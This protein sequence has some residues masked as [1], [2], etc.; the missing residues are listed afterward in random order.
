MSTNEP[1]VELVN[2]EIP[3]YLKD[4]G[5]WVDE[6]CAEAEKAAHSFDCGGYDLILALEY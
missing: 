1:T 6:P 3:T 4:R 2:F 5:L